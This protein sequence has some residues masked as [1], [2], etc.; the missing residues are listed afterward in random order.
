[1]KIESVQKL[2][3]MVEQVESNMQLIQS[4]LYFENVSLRTCKRHLVSRSWAY[5]MLQV[6][7]G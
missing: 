6:I 5:T 1:M 3:L 2:L 4:A 7:I